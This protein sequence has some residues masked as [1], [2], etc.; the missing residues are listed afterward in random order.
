MPVPIFGFQK[1]RGVN[2]APGY[3]V[4]PGNIKLPIGPNVTALPFTEL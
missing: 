2:A 4:H 3:V 1:D